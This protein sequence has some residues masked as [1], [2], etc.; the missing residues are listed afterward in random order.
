MPSETKGIP[1]GVGNLFFTCVLQWK[2]KMF[3]RNFTYCVLNDFYP[4]E[5]FKCFPR[6][7]SINL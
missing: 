1:H 5:I 3:M 4:I 2:S 7:I 6:P